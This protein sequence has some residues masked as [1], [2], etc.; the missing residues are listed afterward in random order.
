MFP[1]II[2]RTLFYY[3]CHAGA[4]DAEDLAQDVLVHILRHPPRIR[5][6]P[7]GYLRASVSHQICN[8]G[9]RVRPIRPLPEDPDTLGISYRENAAARED[10]DHLMTEAPG[11][12]AWLIDYSERKSF[13]ATDRV[14]ALRNR[15]KLRE[16]LAT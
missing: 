15:R 16:V 12:V 13:G 5:T 11:L 4:L 8:Q 7:R 2:S 10:F 6:N 3:A 14:T 1:R 9:R